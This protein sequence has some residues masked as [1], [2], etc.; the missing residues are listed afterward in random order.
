MT[1]DPY[2]IDFPARIKAIQR[3]MAAVAE[4]IAAGDLRVIVRPQSD[5]DLLAKAFASMVANLQRLTA[6]VAEAVDVLGSA[7][8]EIVGSTTQ[9]TAAA[10]R[11]D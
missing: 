10:M 2:F 4:R 11:G 9:L 3:E 8:G 5:K 1:S 6:D 7:A